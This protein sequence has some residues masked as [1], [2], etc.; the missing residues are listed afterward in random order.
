MKRMIW[1]VVLTAICA[2][3]CTTLGPM[4]ATTGISA[5]PSGRPGIEAQVGIVPGYF[6]SEATQEPSHRGEP[7]GQLLALVEPDRL[8]TPGLIIGARDWAR[9]GD[10]AFEP[11]LGY[12]H[13]L[14]DDLALALIGYGTVMRAA[15][16]GASY[17]AIR[18]G[19]ELAVDARLLAPT[20]WLALHGQAAAAATYLDAHGS[21]C[22]G[23][24]GLG[25]D[26][27]EDGSARV[28]DGTIR[29]VFAAATA[30][31]ALDFGRRPAGSFHSFRLA[32]LGTAGVMPQVRDGRETD[33]VHYVA[34]GLTLT[35]GLGSAQ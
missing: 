29:G 35:L 7:I 3:G 5:V 24:T 23:T 1:L 21:Y 17:R 10:G 33:G 19:G 11:F 32:L 31:L 22:A 2:T 9:D 8:G 18:V 4:P 15:E 27:S 34:L 28:I 14:D 16:R 6:L 25:V 20:T 30:T 26:C 13:R 12:R